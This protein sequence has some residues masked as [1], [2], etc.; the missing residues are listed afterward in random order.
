[1]RPPRS[2]MDRSHASSALFKGVPKTEEAAAK[3]V[4]TILKNKE[5]VRKGK[6]Y[7]DTF[8]ESGRGVRTTLD[9]QFVTFVSR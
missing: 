1:M 7:I 4:E 8:D 3:L 9:G 2:H 5:E 6:R